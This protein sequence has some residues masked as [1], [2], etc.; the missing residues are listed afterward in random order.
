MDRLVRG[1]DSMGKIWAQLA[2]DAERECLKGSAAYAYRKGSVYACMEADTRRRTSALPRFPIVDE[3][4]S[5]N[6]GASG[7]SSGLEATP[8]KKVR[9]M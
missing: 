3:G 4:V 2:V 5:G 9:R 1:F 8:R 6:P 7:G